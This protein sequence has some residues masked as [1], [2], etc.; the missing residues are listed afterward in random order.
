MPMKL[1][2]ELFAIKLYELERQYQ[3]MQG[4]IRLCGRQDRQALQQEM[5]RARREYRDRALALQESIKGC[6]S[7]AVAQLAAAQLEIAQ[8]LEDLWDKGHLEKTLCSEQ[9]FPSQ[10]RAEA[11]ALYAEYAMDYAMQAM[12]FALITALYAADQQ[13]AAEEPK[14]ENRP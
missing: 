3:T 4:R 2:E 1:N 13:L 11:A 14:G 9:N 12:Q 8:K 6:R 7:L 5:D 10:T